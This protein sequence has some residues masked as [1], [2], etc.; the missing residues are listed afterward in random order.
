MQRSL[1]DFLRYAAPG[2]FL[3]VALLAASCSG[4]ARMPS[5]PGGG[6]E[7]PGDTAAAAT[8]E[9]RTAS[10]QELLNANRSSL[11]DLHAT[12]HSDIPETLMQQREVRE[13]P[14]DSTAGFRIQIHSSRSLQLADSVA[15]QFRVWADTTL[16]FQADTYTFFQPPFYKVHVGNFRDHRRADAY[17]RLVQRRIPDAW[18]VPD[19][20]EPDRVP[21][22]TTHFG[23]REA[24]QR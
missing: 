14:I 19:R 20:I 6:G 2:L 4:P 18:V 1:P 21:A 12:Q 24:E 3:A 7:A 15:S 16:T 17:S 22:D 23:L 8:D 13:E 11:A 10:E 9:T 5:E